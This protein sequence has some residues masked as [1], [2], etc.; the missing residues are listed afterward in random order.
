MIQVGGRRRRRKIIVKKKRTPP[1]V[2]RC[3]VC[4]GFPLRLTVDKEGNAVAKCAYCGLSKSFTVAAGS[5][6]IDAYYALL[7]VIEGEKGA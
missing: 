3:P 1:K 6:P 7:S 5:E 4:E 2:F